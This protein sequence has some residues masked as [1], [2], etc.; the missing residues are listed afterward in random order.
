MKRKYEK[1][2]MA[3]HLI[4][5]MTLIAASDSILLD[6]LQSEDADVSMPG[7]EIP[8]G[9]ALSRESFWGEW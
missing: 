9:E 1:P 4:Q 5:P 7:G 6:N 3:V 2:L 8:P